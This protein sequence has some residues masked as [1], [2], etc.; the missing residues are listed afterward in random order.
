[1]DLTTKE[2]RAWALAEEQLWLI[3]NDQL[4]TLEFTRPMIR[5]R[6]TTRRLWLVYPGV[7]AVGHRG[8]T[9]ARER[10][11]A[12]LACGQGAALSHL[13]AAVH[14]EIWEGL[15][16]V[17]HHVSVPNRAGRRGAMRDR[18]EEA[19][20]S[21][22]RIQIHRPRSFD[23][24][25][26]TETHEGVRLTTL[27]RTHVDL[28]G[29]LRPAQLPGVLRQSERLHGFDLTRLSDA[30]EEASPTSWRHTRLKRVLNSLIDGASLTHT[31]REALYLD[32]C[33]RHDIPLPQPQKRVGNARRADFLWPEYKLV[34]E[35][36]DRASHDGY[37]QFAD[38]RKRDRELRNLGLEVIRFTVAE[39]QREPLLVATDTMRAIERRRALL[40]LVAAPLVRLG[41]HR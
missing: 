1:M 6:L 37:V 7:Y 30:V 23:P 27:L 41:P 26:D 28:A 5:H 19:R 29:I 14:W 13:S 12:V 2:A 20:S 25:R 9:A 10:M 8:M 35:I 17:R 15:K 34:A 18:P 32:I 24:E 21:A 31:E 11:A 36:D 22:D 33:R 40:G 3:T 38:D 16:P 39:C 4:L